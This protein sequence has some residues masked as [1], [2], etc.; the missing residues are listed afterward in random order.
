MKFQNSLF[1]V[2]CD[3]QKFKKTIHSK[4]I[5]RLLLIQDQTNF[6]SLFE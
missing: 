6:D 1:V 3:P 2:V 4:S 5:Q